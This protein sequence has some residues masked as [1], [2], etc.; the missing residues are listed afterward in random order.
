VKLLKKSR[1][2]KMTI[3][4]EASGGGTGKATFKEFTVTR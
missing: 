3:A 1:M 4:M 2:L